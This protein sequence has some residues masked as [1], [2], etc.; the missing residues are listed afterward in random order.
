MKQSGYIQKQIGFGDTT[1][2]LLGQLPPNAYISEIR[3]LVTQNFDAGS[4]D[5]IDIGT[6]SSANRYANDIDV[7]STGVA[8]V[9]HT[10]FVGAVESVSD[11]TEIY[12]IYVPS[13]SAVT[14]GQCKV[15]ISIGYNESNG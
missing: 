15:I 14:Q 4:T 1:A 8:T 10:A 7:S 12:A 6:S 9:T 5:V 2:T 13:G 11:P 3:V